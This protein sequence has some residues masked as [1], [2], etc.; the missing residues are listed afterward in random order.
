MV[1]VN[2]LEVH[3]CRLLI[4]FYSSCS[5]I[6]DPSKTHLGTSSSGSHLSINILNI[7]SLLDCSFMA[8]QSSLGKLVDTF[9]SGGTSGFD[10]IQ[11]TTFV[12]GKTSNFTS[13]ATT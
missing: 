4:N 2:L 6:S 13:D 5:K 8:S 3:L 10:H 7:L 12:G 1:K 9:I 11:D